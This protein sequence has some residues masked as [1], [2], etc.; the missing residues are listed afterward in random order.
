MGGFFVDV[1]AV[2]RRYA[3]PWFKALF[4]TGVGRA[5]AS[6]DMEQ[7]LE[8]LNVFFTYFVYTNVC[9]SR[10]RGVLRSFSD[11]IRHLHE[12]ASI[13]RGRGRVPRAIENGVAARR[14]APIDRPA[15]SS[16]R[17]SSSSPS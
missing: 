15:G 12:F 7:R 4:A 8:N 13:G 5:P 3:L 14:D 2:P 1:E 16:R 6:N 11:I 17:T 9:R 10:A